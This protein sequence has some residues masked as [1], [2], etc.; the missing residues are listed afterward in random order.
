MINNTHKYFVACIPPEPLFSEL[1]NEKQLISETYHTKGALL[2][3]AHITL[4]MP[5]EW[6][7]K[8]EQQ[9][10]D[11]L[12]A[13]K[14]SVP[15]IDIELNN[16]GCFEPRVL[17]VNV[18][19]TPSLIALQNELVNYMKRTLQLFNQANDLRPFT[20]H[21]TLAFRDLKKEAFYTAWE[22]YHTKA[23]KTSY[24]HNT[25]SLLRKENKQWII[26]KTYTLA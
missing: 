12:H 2:S 21:I 11:T 1:E 6:K 17:Y 4:H 3:P 15:A 9:L 7:V 10:I 18:N 24:T 8:K 25:F 13:F 14:T 5:F 19:K 22:N 20:P 16:Y 26:C 23:F